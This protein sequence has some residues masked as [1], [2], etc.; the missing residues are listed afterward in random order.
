[1]KK[2]FFDFLPILLFF[3]AYKFFGIYIATGVAIFASTVQVSTIWYLHRRVESMHIITL[4]LICV[5]GGATLFFRD[6]MFIKWKPTAI[7]WAFALVF[8]G[9][10]Y[11]GRKPIIRRLMEKNLELPD[12]V[13][14]KLNLSWVAFFIAL[15]TINLYV[16]YNFN[17]D[18]WV[19]FKLFGMLG[20]TIVFVIIQSFFLTKYI[21]VE[22]KTDE[23][24]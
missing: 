10:Q 23:Q 20:L 7:N 19:N 21:D 22:N 4:V 13:W 3:I 2:L 6:E 15:G 8:L 16:I 14:V 5:L 11:I 24:R 17:T 18:T 9:S 12:F 1:M